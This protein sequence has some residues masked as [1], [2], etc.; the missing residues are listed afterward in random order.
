VN[1]EIVSRLSSGDGSVTAAGSGGGSN[2][3]TLGWSASGFA[4]IQGGNWGGT[5]KSVVL[6]GG[7]GI[8]GIGTTGPDQGKLEVTG[9]S[10]CVDTNSDA[11][12]T[13][14]IASESD[15]RLKKNVQDLSYS[16]DTL[17]K[18]RPVSF[19]W[20]YDDPEVLKHYDLVSRFADRPHSIGLIAQDVQKLI[21]EAIEQE[22]VGDEEIQYLQLDYN[23]LVPVVIKAVQ[24]LKSGS[25]ALSRENSVIRARLEAIAIDSATP[26]STVALTQDNQLVTVG[27]SSLVVVRSNAAQAS[28]TFCL[29]AGLGAGQRLLVMQTGA[30]GSQLED[31]AA[32][33]C[34]GADAP[35]ELAGG[36]MPFNAGNTLELVWDG[37]VWRELNRSI[38]N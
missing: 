21:P 9:G 31:S 26:P 15:G 30:N 36:P 14:C 2:I 4:Y 32:P 1:G 35:A 3:A 29:T 5:T 20:R 12:A 34:A 17:M 38:N 28:R 11:N 33:S 25:D 24:E 8:V 7:G 23:K 37:S 10:V 16:L 22:T 13:S 18:L 27:N 6:Q 19:D